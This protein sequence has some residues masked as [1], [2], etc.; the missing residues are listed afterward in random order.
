M[1]QQLM[2]ELQEAIDRVLARHITPGQTVIKN[3]VISSDPQFPMQREF[4]IDGKVYYSHAGGITPARSPLWRDTN[5]HTA[6]G[7]DLDLIAESYGIKRQLD[8]S[9][10]MENDVYIRDRIM[11]KG[12]GGLVAHLQRPFFRE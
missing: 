7:D 4:K 12:R 10:H 2:L 3:V 8:A 1:S 5:V 11:N 6:Q 9:G